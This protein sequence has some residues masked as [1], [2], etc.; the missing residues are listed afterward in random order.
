ME[1]NQRTSKYKLNDLIEISLFAAL[2]YLSVAI[3]KIPVGV[4]MVHL[5]NAMVLA[6]ALVFGARKG[7]I[8]ATIGLSIFDITHSYISECWLTVLESLIVCLFVYIIFEKLMKS[9]QG[10]TN[11]KKLTM[12]YFVSAF[13]A[14]LKVI[15]N[16]LKYTF[17]KNMLLS[18]MLFKPAFAAALVKITGSYGSA[19]L[20]FILTPLLAVVLSKAYYSRLKVKS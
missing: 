1:T 6:I 11:S 20:T 16:L 18:G 17:Y 4:Q 7:A 13:C 19:V 5:G 2:I 12:L 15:L 9:A 8:S 14:V 10:V 3:F